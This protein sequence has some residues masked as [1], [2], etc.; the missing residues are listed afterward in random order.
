MSTQGERL[1]DLCIGLT[2]SS[3]AR[4]GSLLTFEELKDALLM[5]HQCL[6]LTKT[7]QSVFKGVLIYAFL[8]ALDDLSQDN[9]TEQEFNITQNLLS[10]LVKVSEKELLESL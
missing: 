9:G 3:S 7:E 4:G 10:S 1:L 5:Y 2:S 6:P 8:A